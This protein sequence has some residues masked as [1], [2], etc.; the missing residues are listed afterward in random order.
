M[1]INQEFQFPSNE[2]LGLGGRVLL[3]CCTVEGLS[4]ASDPTPT[5]QHQLLWIGSSSLDA[6]FQ[7]TTSL[8]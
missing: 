8:Q 3:A 2:A 5:T 7:N 4:L 1:K 6:E